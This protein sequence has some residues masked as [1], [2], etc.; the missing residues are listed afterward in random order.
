MSFSNKRWSPYKKP[1]SKSEELPQT[2]EI[3]LEDHPCDSDEED[4]SGSDMEESDLVDDVVESLV[5][6][7]KE[8]EERL[9]S[10]EKEWRQSSISWNKP[11]SES[12]VQ[13]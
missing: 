1:R 13:V 10:L 6:K 5:L 11:L 2:Q 9:S 12:Q 4:I 3:E 8:L 7:L